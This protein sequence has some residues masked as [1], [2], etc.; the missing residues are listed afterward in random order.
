M[1]RTKKRASATG[2]LSPNITL[3]YGIIMIVLAAIIS[4]IFLNFFPSNEA[5]MPTPQAS[6]SRLEKYEFALINFTKFFL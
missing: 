6:C 3:I 2:Q 5:I 1:E 4:T